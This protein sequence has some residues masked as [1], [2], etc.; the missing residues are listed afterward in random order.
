N[1]T[2]LAETSESKRAKKEADLRWFLFNA[3]DKVLGRLSTQVAVKLMGKDQATYRP[4]L[5]PRAAVIVVNAKS[6]VL[7]GQK[8]TDK[9]YY[10][11]SGY[12]GGLKQLT[13]KGLREEKSDEI[14]RHAVKGMLPKNKLADKVIS[15]LFIYESGDHSHEAQK[16]IEVEL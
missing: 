4:N 14:I 10:R 5:D 6:V 8:E 15:R 11:Y 16:P 13:P 2:R 3:K 1:K 12:P 9:K 7:T